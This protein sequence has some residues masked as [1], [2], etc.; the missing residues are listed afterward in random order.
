LFLGN[1]FRTEFAAGKQGLDTQYIHVLGQ[2]PDERGSG[3]LSYYATTAPLSQSL[4]AVKLAA[5]LERDSPVSEP[6]QE[7]QSCRQSTGKIGAR[8]PTPE[9][10][11]LNFQHN[12][13][14]LLNCSQFSL[15][16]G[17]WIWLK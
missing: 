14:N 6:L 8:S 15:L 13:P 12:S 4:P 10:A 11:T 7:S 3:L 1:N 5:A 2:R 16:P 17:M 9:Y